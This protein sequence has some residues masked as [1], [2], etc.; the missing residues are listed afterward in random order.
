MKLFKNGAISRTKQAVTNL[1]KEVITPKLL[2]WL[3][4]PTYE[5][6]TDTILARIGLYIAFLGILLGLFL[7]IYFLLVDPIVW[8]DVSITSFVIL[9]CTC[10]IF[11]IKT[12]K[13]RIAL[14]LLVFIPFSGACR[15]PFGALPATSFFCFFC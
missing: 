2:K 15:F 9:T 1:G 3:L 11:F 13:W 5:N 12:R 8:V 4:G 10:A 7:T 14:G 6:Q